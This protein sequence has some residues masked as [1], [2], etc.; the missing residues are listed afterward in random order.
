MAVKLGSHSLLFA[1]D[2]CNIEPK[3]Y[4]HL[5]EEIGEV[6][7]LFL[8]MECDGA[9]LTWL[10]RAAAFPENRT[11]HGCVAPLVGSNCEQGMQI[12]KSFRCRDVYVYAMGQEPWLNYMMSI[13]Y[14]ESRPIVESNKLIKA[15]QEQGIIAERLFGDQEIWLVNHNGFIFAVVSL[16]SA[17]SC[18]SLTNSK[19]AK[20]V[21]SKARRAAVFSLLRRTSCD[22]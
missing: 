4:Q 8:G 6:D 1:A 15:C 21:P 5:H 2:S 11:Q 16:A 10:L 12:V 18:C 14:T 13:K 3:L 22:P 17:G 9:P 7:A 20:Y 19:A